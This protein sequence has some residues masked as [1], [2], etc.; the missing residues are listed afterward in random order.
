MTFFIKKKHNTKKKNPELA[1]KHLMNQK[2]NFKRI[3]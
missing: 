3:T 1:W 2:N